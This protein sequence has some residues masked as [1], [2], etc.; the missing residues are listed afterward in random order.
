VE[1]FNPALRLYKRLGF[2]QKEDKGVYLLMEWSPENKE[3]FNYG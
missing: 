3:Q 1:Q 2:H